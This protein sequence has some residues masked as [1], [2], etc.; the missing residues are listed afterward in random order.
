MTTFND[1]AAPVYT[2]NNVYIAIK[3]QVVGFVE[4]LSITRGVN[5][6]PTYQVGGPL[7]VDAPVTQATVTVTAT[8]MVPVQGQPG[9][10]AS[11]GSQG[12]VPTSSLANEVYASSYPITVLDGQTGQPV[13]YVQDAFYNQDAIQTPATDIVTYNLSWIARD[14]Q[15]WT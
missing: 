15:A 9:S 13:W 1:A 11:L 7:F 5:R 14:T 2:G 12:I 3:N 10:G 8:N 6:R 4:T